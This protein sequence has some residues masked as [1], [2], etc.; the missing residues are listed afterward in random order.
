MRGLYSMTTGYFAYE[1]VPVLRIFLAK[2]EF[3]QVQDFVTGSVQVPQPI[4]FPLEIG[5]D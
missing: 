3:H 4:T 5:R 2:A 1:S